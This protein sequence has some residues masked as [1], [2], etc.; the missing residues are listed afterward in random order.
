MPFAGQRKSCGRLTSDG[1]CET[2]GLGMLNKEMQVCSA[3]GT[4]S[5]CSVPI[6]EEEGKNQSCGCRM[7]RVR[8]NELRSNISPVNG[9]D[10]VSAA[11]RLL[12]LI[13]QSE[14]AASNV[15]SHRRRGDQ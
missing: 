1:P 7:V 6:G 13:A 9:Q 14:R 2:E 11:V 5:W 15:S 3:S 12:P 10:S 8:R 4:K